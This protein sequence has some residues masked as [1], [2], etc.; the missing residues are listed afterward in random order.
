MATVELY[1]IP[2]GAGG[3][4]VRVNG[5]VYEALVAARARRPRQ[6]LFHSALLVRSSGHTYAVE[7]TPVADAAASTRGVV[8][9]G[10]VGTRW[11]G[12]FRLFR[13]EVRRWRD[14]VIPDLTF[15]T[16]RHDLSAD[17][18]AARR[19]LA[20]LPEVPPLIWGRDELRAGEMWSCNS[21]ISWALTAA[22]IDAEAIP[23]PAGGRAP[24]WDAGIALAGRVLAVSPATGR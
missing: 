12:R 5:I 9:E 16:A 19:V 24:G 10:P 22:G 17:E 13:Y 7:M 20:V 18:T 6:A 8:V 23:L 21:I 15:A 3:R 2:L 1:W 11:A 14:G 4:V